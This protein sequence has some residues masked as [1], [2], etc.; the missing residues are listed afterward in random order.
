MT[1]VL[2]IAGLAAA[3]FV[4]YILRG[5]HLILTPTRGH[6]IDRAARPGE[7]LVVI[8]MQEDFTRKAKRGYDPAD[9]EA[10]IGAVNSLAREARQAGIPVLSVRQMVTAPVAAAVGR[11]LA[12]PEGIA[13]SPGIGLDRRLELGAERDFTKERGDAFSNPELE[14][15]LDQRH[16]GRLR[17]VGLDGCHCVQRT[18]RGALNRGYAVEIVESGVLAADRPAW[19]DWRSKLEAMGAAFHTPAGRGT[20]TPL[21]ATG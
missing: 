5:I 9:V 6:K 20:E 13:G 2:W 19:S 12:G 3:G 18:A 21:R 11:I 1:S 17:I 10:A 7:A 14:R 16:V 4:A 8:D 15:W